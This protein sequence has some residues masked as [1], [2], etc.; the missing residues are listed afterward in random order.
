MTSSPWRVRIIIA[1]GAVIALILL[2][3]A[4][5]TQV[6]F[7]CVWGSTHDM[8]SIRFE[9]FALQWV[10]QEFGG[11]TVAPGPLPF[12]W[13][14]AP[15][16]TASLLSP[17]GATL[18]HMTVVSVPF[19]M[20]ILPAGIPL[21]VLIHRHWRGRRRAMRGCCRTCGY[22]LDGLTVIDGARTC[23]ECGTR[24]RRGVKSSGPFQDR[25]M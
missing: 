5:S 6:Q 10:H 22:R 23:P 11:G 8:Q 2:L 13:R 12:S 9:R 1:L 24:R 20:L 25:A 17:P 4:A 15:P 16:G 19:L 14:S 3:C 18:Q 7:G 21:G